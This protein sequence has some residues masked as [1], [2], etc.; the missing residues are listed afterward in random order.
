MT[1][2]FEYMSYDNAS[3]LTMCE[4]IAADDEDTSG[5]PPPGVRTAEDHSPGPHAPDGRT[6]A[7]INRGRAPAGRAAPSKGRPGA[8]GKERHRSGGRGPAVLTDLLTTT[9]DYPGHVR[10]EKPAAYPTDSGLLAGAV[11]KLV[12]TAGRVR[13]VRHGRP[14]GSDDA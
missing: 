3:Q 1:R 2:S 13:A 10:N 5:Q 7:L 14:A 6:E 9:L 8:A 4:N 11:G 12:R